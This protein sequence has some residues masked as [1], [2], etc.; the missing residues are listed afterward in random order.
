METYSA[1]EKSG[2]KDLNQLRKRRY[3]WS[4][5]HGK[6]LRGEGLLDRGIS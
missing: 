4:E 5:V 2:R 6:V 1:A 3:P